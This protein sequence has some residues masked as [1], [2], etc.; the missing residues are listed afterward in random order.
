MSEILKQVHIECCILLLTPTLTVSV[1]PVPA[2]PRGFPPRC[3]YMAVVSVSTQRSVSGVTTS[4]PL[5]P[6]NITVATDYEVQHQ[7]MIAHSRVSHQAG[8]LL[9]VQVGNND[10]AYRSEPRQLR[11]E[12]LHW[13]YRRYRDTAKGTL[14]VF[15]AQPRWKRGTNPVINSKTAITRSLAFCTRGK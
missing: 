5:L 8:L 1:F 14:L 13:W 15:T 3:R 7:P 12:P 4:R 6:C 2:G 10:I 9:P 11:R